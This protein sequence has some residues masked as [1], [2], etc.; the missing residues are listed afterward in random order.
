MLLPIMASAQSEIIK[1]VEIDDFFYNL[2]PED[3][4][5]IVVSNPYK[6]YSGD[7][8]IPESVTYEG[9]EYTVTDFGP[10][11][12][13]CTDLTSVVIPATVTGI[14]YETFLG[15]TKLTSVNLPSGLKGIADHAF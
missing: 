11:F 6:R 7:I 12:Y 4:I 2:R 1:N 3:K 9:T 5:A 13:Q 14:G 8:V 10:A 15:C